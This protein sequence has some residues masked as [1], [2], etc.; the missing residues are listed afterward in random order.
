M[1]FGDYNNDIEMLQ[2]GY[3][4]YAMK[5]AH[6]DV[7]KV[8]RFKTTSNSDGGVEKVI[9]QLLNNNK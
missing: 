4:S 1:V 3:F 5:N 2:L 6:P 7:R 8:A 9:E